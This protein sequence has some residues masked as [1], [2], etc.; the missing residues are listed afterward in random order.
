[1]RRDAITQLKDLLK[2]KDVS[3]DDERKA[4]EDI[5]KMTDKS[6]AEIDKMMAAKEAEVMAV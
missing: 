6:V 3:E 5:Q 2:A 1:V 4:S